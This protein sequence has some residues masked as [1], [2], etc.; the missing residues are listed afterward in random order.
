VVE[1]E[2]GYR[3]ELGYPQ[4]LALICPLCAW[5]RGVDGSRPPGVVIRH[6]GGRM[7]P[8]CGPHVDLCR[9]HGYPI[10]RLLD[11]RVVER[12]LLDAYAVEV[13]SSTRASVTT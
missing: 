2:H 10:R 7:I 11:A 13:L 9:R 5:R 3:A 8:L 1:H 6:R 4:R 12:A